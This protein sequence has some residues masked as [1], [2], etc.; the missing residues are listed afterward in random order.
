MG[1]SA[2]YMQ[3]RGTRPVTVPTTDPQSSSQHLLQVL[4]AIQGSAED[5]LTYFKAVWYLCSGGMRVVGKTSRPLEFLPTHVPT[6]TCRI[7]HPSVPIF[8]ANISHLMIISIWWP[9]I[10]I[11]YQTFLIFLHCTLCSAQGPGAIVSMRE[12][13]VVWSG[14]HSGLLNTNSWPT[15]NNCQKRAPG[16]VS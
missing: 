10:L 9:F 5:F 11:C 2:P 8:W 12:Q 7:C 3:W 16:K 13:C 1:R 6:C 15:A 4:N 14:P